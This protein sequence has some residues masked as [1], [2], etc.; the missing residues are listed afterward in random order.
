MQ[1][2]RKPQQSLSTKISLK[3][4]R[5]Q[6]W[7]LI[8]PV[9]AL[10]FIQGLPSTAYHCPGKQIIAPGATNALK[11][12]PGCT[13]QR[14]ALRCFNVAKFHCTATCVLHFKSSSRAAV[15]RQCRMS[16]PHRPP[17]CKSKKP[18]QAPL[19]S[20]KSRQCIQ[21]SSKLRDICT[22]LTFSQVAAIVGHITWSPPGFDLF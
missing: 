1:G 19:A 11:M 3:C 15:R 20:K 8:V 14:N 2:S 17:S 9:E 10:H 18:S 5:L 13:W 7:H 16:G 6:L 4:K 22:F 12:L 21:I